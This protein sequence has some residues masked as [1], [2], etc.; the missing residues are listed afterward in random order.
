MTRRE[1]K[2]QSRQV[3]L[4]FGVLF[5]VATGFMI[6]GFLRDHMRDECQK[7]KR[8][9][10]MDKVTQVIMFLASI[11]SIYILLKALGAIHKFCQRAS[12]MKLDPPRLSSDEEDD[13]EYLRHF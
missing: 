2:V 5:Q 1:L 4:L 10:R 9:E 13:S 3:D 12:R 6:F 11:T 7:D 8:F